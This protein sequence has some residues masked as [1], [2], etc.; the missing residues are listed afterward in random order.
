MLV[1]WLYP[2]AVAAASLVEPTGKPLWIKVHG[3][4]RFHLDHPQRRKLILRTCSKAAG[5]ICVSENVA[6]VLRAA[7]VAAEQVHV[8]PNGV[9][10]QRFRYRAREEAMHGLPQAAARQGGHV[11]LYVGNLTSIKG[12]D[13]LLDAWAQLLCAPGEF[14]ARLIFAGDGTLRRTLEQKARTLGIGDSVLFLGSVPHAEVALWMNLADCLCLPS[15]SEGM[16]NA[17]LEA[18]VSGLP[19]VASDVGACR[20]LLKD[21]PSSCLVPVGNHSALSAAILQ[22]LAQ[23]VDRV[24]MAARH[25]AKY[26]WA[27]SAELVLTVIKETID[28]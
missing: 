17:V 18:L 12:P 4:D 23:P 20:E 21:E 1:T 14:K 7:G 27:R 15:L 24:G 10:H 26:S 5:V 13:V 6:A 28:D 25:A 16:P 3:T 9:D 2:D 19:V 8:V 11:V 22:V